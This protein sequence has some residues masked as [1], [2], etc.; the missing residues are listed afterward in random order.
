MKVFGI[1]SI[2]NVQSESWTCL[3]FSFSGLTGWS[4]DLINGSERV[5]LGLSEVEELLGV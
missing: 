2:L 4:A 1:G 5:S 3:G